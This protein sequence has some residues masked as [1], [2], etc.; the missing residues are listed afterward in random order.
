VAGEII[1]L[2]GIFNITDPLIHWQLYI[3]MLIIGCI[4]AV[5]LH[6]GFKY[7]PWKGYEAF[8]GLYYAFKASSNAAFIS[9]LQLYFIMRSEADAKCIF[10]YGSYNYELTH[11]RLPDKLRRFLFYY[12]TAYLDDIDW[13]HALV[14]KYGHKNMDVEIAKKLQNYE[15][16]EAPSTTIGGIR[17]DIILDADLWVPQDTPQHKA[18]EAACYEW[19]DAHPEDQIHSYHK[20]QRLMDTGLLK[21]P[22]GVKKEVVVPWQRVDSAFPIS[23][24]DNES[25]GFRRQAAEEMANAEANSLNRYIF[26][27]ICGGFG[28]PAL[29]LLLKWFSM[30]H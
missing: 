8:W 4:T 3:W 14:Y 12:P 1:F 6:V 27:L 30:P 15:W 2:G 28:L 29:M 24:E 10:K 26:P 20:F 25:A 19:N 5:V 11:S 17:T 23:M 13:A 7:G 16:E 21:P 9:G 18:I 22:V